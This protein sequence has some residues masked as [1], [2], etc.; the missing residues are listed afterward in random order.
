MNQTGSPN[1]KTTWCTKFCSLE[2]NPLHI[3]YLLGRHDLSS[4][5]PSTDLRATVLTHGS[6]QAWENGAV[7]KQI[8]S[9]EFWKPVRTPI[10]LLLSRFLSEFRH[11]T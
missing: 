1:F 4:G 6:C 5:F 8:F 7:R 2:K 11:V 10:P 9:K 3:S